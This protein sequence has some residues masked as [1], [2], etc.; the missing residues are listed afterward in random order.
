[1]R[2]EIQPRASAEKTRVRSLLEYQTSK[3]VILCYGF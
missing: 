1:M 3:V 2:L